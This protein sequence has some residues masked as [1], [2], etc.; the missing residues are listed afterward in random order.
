MASF[1][2]NGVELGGRDQVDTAEELSIQSSPRPYVVTF[3]SGPGAG[4]RLRDEILK[5]PAPLLVVDKWIFENY[6]VE[7][8]GLERVPRFEVPATEEK[9]SIETVLEII[10]F[11]EKHNASKS[12]MV[13]AAGGGIIQDLAAFSAYMF[14]RGIPWTFVPT[15]LLAQGDSSVGGKTALNYRQTKNLLA[16]FSAPKRIITDTDFLSTLSFEDW[17]SGGGEILR[18]CITGGEQSL[19]ELEHGVAAFVQ[20]D[21]AVTTHLIRVSL[22]VKKAVVEFDEFELDIR[23]SMNYGHSFGHALEALTNYRIV[24]GIGVALGILVE[25]EISYL[26]GIL[27]KSQRD[28]ILALTNHFVSD[29]VWEIFRQAKL[30]GIIDLLKRDKK[31]EGP[32][33]KLATLARVGQIVF[34]DLHLDSD[35]EFEVRKA[36][37][38]VLEAL[39]RLRDA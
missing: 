38:S 30:D 37:G 28:R 6:L 26:R 4:S 11:L 18:L 23:R 27:P 33:L 9:K 20:R 36:Y 1:I 32:V 17:L 5:H 15:T 31:A 39:A 14:K 7:E 22:R 12:S 13:F 24:H 29:R 10:D 21:L 35:G 3:H 25:N 19:S 16:L 2:I 8:P 34:I